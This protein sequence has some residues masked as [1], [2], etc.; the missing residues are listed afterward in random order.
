M[1]WAY[2]KPIKSV[3]LIGEFIEK[4]G[5][6]FCDSF[7]ECVKRNNGGRPSMRAFVTEE[8]NEHEIK[9]FLSFNKDEKENIWKR[10][11]ESD[12]RHIPFAIGN[13]GNLICFDKQNGNVVL[14]NQGNNK[15]EAVDGDFD[16]FQKNCFMTEVRHA[17]DKLLA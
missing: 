14:V 9:T 7:R 16:S 4:T 12:K 2:V 10:E 8:D 5:Y 11:Y 1:S 6:G 17:I 15:T 13:F 3:D